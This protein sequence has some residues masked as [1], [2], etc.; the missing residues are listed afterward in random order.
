MRDSSWKSGSSVN[1][2][3]SCQRSAPKPSAVSP[4]ATTPASFERRPTSTPTPTG[5]AASEYNASFEIF[6]LADRATRV[7]SH[8]SPRRGQHADDR[9]D[10]R[11]RACQGGEPEHERRDDA[12]FG[13]GLP[14]RQ[15]EYDR[16]RC[17]QAQRDPVLLDVEPARGLRGA[18]DELR[19]RGELGGVPV[20]A[21]LELAERASVDRLRIDD[22]R[23]VL[24]I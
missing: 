23:R 5:T 6:M 14:Q 1:N 13:F 19:G 4:P 10:P 18:L 17:K 21:Q 2:R 22:R 12:R 9:G 11:R 15:H 7:P 16:R 8:R 20:L 3:P 24:E